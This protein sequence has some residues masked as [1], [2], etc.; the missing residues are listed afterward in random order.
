MKKYVVYILFGT[1]LF[2]FW[3]VFDSY[4]QLFYARIDY[5]PIIEDAANRHCIDPNLLEAL[6]WQESRFRVNIRG[7]HNE[8]GLMQIRPSHGAASDWSTH[9]KI[10]IPCEGVLF[11][12]GL[13]IEIGAWYLGRALR[14]WSGYDYQYELALS[15]YNAGR[16]GMTPW[17]PAD[18]NGEV[19]ERITIPSTKAYVKSIMAKFRKI[20]SQ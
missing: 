4:K 3:Y 19:V 12:P 5:K 14:K 6:I 20:S 11:N 9:H 15:E 7:A 17:I 16:K 18:Y 13:N 2:L 1:L 8:V 10:K